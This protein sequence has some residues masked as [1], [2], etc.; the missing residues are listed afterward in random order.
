MVYGDPCEKVVGHQL[1][2]MP[3]GIDDFCCCAQ[4]GLDVVFGFRSLAQKEFAHAALSALMAVLALE[5]VLVIHDN[6][7]V[8]CVRARRCMLA[9]PFSHLHSIRVTHIH[10]WPLRAIDVHGSRYRNRTIA[11]DDVM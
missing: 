2:E 1:R 9:F 11:F 10:R 3:G 5:L 4:M 6:P 8:A 7:L